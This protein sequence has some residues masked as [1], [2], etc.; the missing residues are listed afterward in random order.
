M[1]NQY[2]HHRKYISNLFLLNKVKIKVLLVFLFILITKAFTITLIS[3]I[4]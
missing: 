3:I 4:Y 1:P 2:H